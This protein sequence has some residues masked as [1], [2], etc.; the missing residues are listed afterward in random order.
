MSIQENIKQKARN[1]DDDES[2]RDYLM[3]RQGGSKEEKRQL[4]CNMGKRQTSHLP[5]IKLSDQSKVP[6]SLTK[7]S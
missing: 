7:L 1:N 6:Y 2:N 3:S 4:Y 5:F